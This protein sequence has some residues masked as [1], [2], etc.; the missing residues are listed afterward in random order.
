LTFPAAPAAAASYPVSLPAATL[1]DTLFQ[2]SRITGVQ[3]AF[4][5][6]GLARLRAR[7][8]RGRF[9][10]RDLLDRATNGAGVTYRFLTPT[11][12][13]ISRAPRTA[14]P[15]RPV[16]PPPPA[17]QDAASMATIVV[18]ATRR[19]TPLNDVPLSGTSY[20]QVALDR[21]GLDDMRG[22]ARTTPGVLFRNGWGSSTNLSIRGIYS[23]TG[24]ATTG[25]YIDDTPIQTRSLGA[26][27]TSTNIYPALFDLQRVEVLRGPQGALF[28]SGSEG[29]TV[30][31]ITRV[32]DMRNT[33]GAA[34]LE[35]MDTR[36]GE[37]GYEA[38]AAIGGPIVEDKLAFRIAGFARR[39]GGWTDRVS[40]PD[41]A[42]ID[43]NTNRMTGKAIRAAIAARIGENVTVTPSIFYQ[44]WRQRDT[45]L[46]WSTVSDIDAGRFANGFR[47]GQPSSDSFLLGTLK[48]EA[49][50]D[51]V[52]LTSTTSYFRRRRPSVVDYTDYFTEMFS[53]GEV[54]TVDEVPD[55]VSKVD[56]DNDQDVVTQEFRL[57][58][59]DQAPVRWVGGVFVQR[60]QQDAIEYIYEPYL[61]QAIQAITGQ[62]MLEYFGSE[63]LADGISYIGKD[64]SV[65][66]QAALFGQAD[67]PLWREIE[68]TVGGRIAWMHF[69]QTNF[70]DGPQSGVIPP[71][72]ISH[73]ETPILPRIGLTWR[74]EKGRLFYV[75]A[76]KGTRI[77][78]GN[79]PVS[80]QRCGTY[81]DAFG[82]EQVPDRFTSDSIWNYEVGA[83]LDL[84]V[85][86]GS[87]HASAFHFRWKDIQQSYSL[88]CLFRFTANNARARGEGAELML[89][90][91][92]LT[93]L[94]L[95][96]AGSY[97]RARFTTNTLG[98]V[99]DAETGTRSLVIPKGQPL[100][101]PAWR[102]SGLLRY[103]WPVAL[104]IAAHLAMSG[105]HAS[106]YAQGYAPGA[107]DHDPMTYRV[108]AISTLR[109]EA[110]LRRGDWTATLYAENALDSRDVIQESHNQRRSINM[111]YAI[112]RPRTIGFR[113]AYRFE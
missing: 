106:G 109:L 55:Y 17:E 60:A 28:G 50:L 66:W 47:L 67:I 87:L 77:G 22:I 25:V 5:E 48:V 79:P 62:T 19:N 93:G 100:P 88:R 94:T 73:G 10:L 15:R 56:F 95:S 75:N 90:S 46:F 18:S 30:R 49:D 98:G 27:T 45:D 29:G 108:D 61:P 54:F 99:I 92:P 65:D 2:V 7:P 52:A 103:E 110:G 13:M 70:Q 58:G 8:V 89:T 78:G 57:T 26:G 101:T 84:P 74:P 40:Y 104:D 43:P 9:G 76:A 1:S 105:D 111:R 64:R 86:G 82:Y 51:D 113:L 37:M 107:I 4:A 72:T 91:K 85:I 83:K 97:T 3:F 53:R 71:S 24:S 63:M 42:M 23:N 81:L 21:R 34:S 36:G 102:I 80:R 12:V 14:V 69:R 6:P 32:P 41:G 11:T 20:S 96:L 68:L 38:S 35:L 31:F 39:E 112:V 44:R 16:A 33:S 59:S